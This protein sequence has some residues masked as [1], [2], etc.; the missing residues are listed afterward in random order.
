[1]PKRESIEVVVGAPIPCPRAE[2]PSQGRSTST[3]PST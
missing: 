2:K 1:M 3:T